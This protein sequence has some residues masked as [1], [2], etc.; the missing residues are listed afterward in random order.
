MK[1]RTVPIR[2]WCW[3]RGNT[4]SRTLQTAKQGHT[5]RLQPEMVQLSV[6]LLLGQGDEPAPTT[7]VLAV[8]PHGLNAVLGMGKGMTGCTKHPARLPLPPYGCGGLPAPLALSVP[9]N[10]GCCR[11]ALRG[12]CSRRDVVP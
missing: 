6:P 4:T 12:D 11:G 3:D 10:T 5:H 9:H 2:A 1:P 8:F 7:L